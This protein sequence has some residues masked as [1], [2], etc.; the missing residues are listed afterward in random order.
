MDPRRYAFT[1]SFL[2]LAVAGVASAGNFWKNDE[3]GKILPA[4]E[5]FRLMPV[6]ARGKT[7]RVEWEIA[8]GY[9]LYLNRLKFES[10]EPAATLGT[11]KLPA[12][13]KFHDEH[14]GDVLIHR[15]GKLVA[16][17]PV[18]QVPKS[19]KLSYQGCAETGV[20]LPPQN[21]RVEVYPVP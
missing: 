17:L 7:L 4:S 8:P 14:F 3:L 10:P 2:L 21:V 9:Y 5:A 12:G 15:A 20:C 13:E 6:E 16:E 19:L 18:Q 11:P 1:L